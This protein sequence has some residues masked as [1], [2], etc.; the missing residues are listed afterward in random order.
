MLRRPKGSASRKFIQQKV[1]GVFF[2]PIEYLEG[3]DDIN[4]RLVSS[5]QA[6]NIP[7]VMLDRTY[8]PYP[9]ESSVDLVGIDNYRAGFVLAYHLGQQ[10]AR[11][12]VFVARRR[13]AN[14]VFERID[15]YK[16]AIRSL[17]H[18]YEGHV[19]FGD[20]EDEGLI[21][22]MLAEERPD[23]IVC[24]NDM[25]AAKLMRTLIDLGKRIPDDIRMVG[26][27]DVS[28]ARY[29]PVPLTTIHQNCDLMGHMAMMLMLD[30]LRNPKR[31]PVQMHVGFE[32]V[33]R[34][35]CGTRHNST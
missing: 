22:K 1:A 29:L 34:E 26:V 7:V 32:L 3:D 13:S 5:L 9:L 6:E 8:E 2:A 33:V 14:T 23:G 20:V 21:A 30:R 27:D 28:F 16:A 35:S 4:A 24:G 17:K 19:F 12:I 25:T 31:S 11:R 10:G 15:G 18:D